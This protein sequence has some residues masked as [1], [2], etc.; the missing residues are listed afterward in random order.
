MIDIKTRRL[1]MK[2]FVIDNWRDLQNIFI[3]FESS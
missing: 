2:N 3:D 1:E